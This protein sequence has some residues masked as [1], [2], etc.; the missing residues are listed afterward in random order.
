[1]EITRNKFATISYELRI[2]DMNGELVEKTEETNPLAFVVG[3]GKM[4]QM[5][6]NKLEGLKVGDAFNFELKPEEAYGDANPQAIVELPKNIFEVN[7]AIDESLFELGNH[8]PMQDAQGNRLDGIVL[9]VTDE[10]VKMDF[11]HPLAGD[12]LFFSGAVIEV[13]EASEDEI[14]EAAGVHDSCSTSEG[15]CSSCGSGC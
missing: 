8:V 13:R 10:N 11:N 1:M 7:G 5:F 3:A 14:A 15:G 9:E 6:E 12:I 4:L 2:N